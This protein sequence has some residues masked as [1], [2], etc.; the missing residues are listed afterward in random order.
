MERTKE[1]LANHPL[2]EQWIRWQEDPLT[3]R[4]KG[5]MKQWRMSLMEQWASGGFSSEDPDVTAAAT[6]QALG[7][8]RLLDGLIAQEFADFIETIDPKEDEDE[9]Q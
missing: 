9:S 7:Q 2:A 5:M 8:V 4:Y 3:Q 6:A 1:E